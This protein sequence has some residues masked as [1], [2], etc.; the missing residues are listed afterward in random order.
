MIKIIRENEIILKSKYVENYKA[1]IKMI[2]KFRKGVY[3]NSDLKKNQT[4]NFY[5]FKFSRPFNGFKIS[6]IKK[7]IGKKTKKKLFKNT[8]VNLKDFH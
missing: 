1:E 2:K 6:E 7:L 5:N 8:S 3:L 4:V